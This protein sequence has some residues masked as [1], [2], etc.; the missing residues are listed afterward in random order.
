MKSIVFSASFCVLLASLL[1]A[2][3]S[4]GLS[5]SRTLRFQNPVTLS[6][7]DGR[8]TS[9]KAG[10]SVPM[11]R[12]PVRIEAPG[13]VSLLVVP[14]EGGS[15]VSEIKMRRLDSWGGPELKRAVNIQLNKVLERVV[16]AQRAL[17]RRSGREALEIL[18]DLESSHPELTYLNF[19]KASAYVLQGERESA[20]RAVEAGLVAFPDNPS[21]LA[22]LKSLSG[23][24]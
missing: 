18:Q 24:R 6:G 16:E 10:E 19:L 11:P 14:L 15:G 17:S 23:G 22:L 12:E 20:R 9:Y 13:Q 2:C 1:G 7:S 4:S 8:E 21:G 5:D 3:A